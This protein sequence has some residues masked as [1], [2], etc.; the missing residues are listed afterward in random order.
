MTENESTVPVT[1]TET[2]LQASA[3][4]AS[5]KISEAD[6]LVLERAANKHQ[7]SV[8]TAKA[9]VAESETTELQ[10]KNVVMQ[11]F[12]RYGLTEKDTIA[13]DGSVTRAVKV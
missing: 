9:A 12:M 1:A 6:M 8:A 5:E 4:G 2:T 7:L 11:L 10:Y 3:G 13:Q